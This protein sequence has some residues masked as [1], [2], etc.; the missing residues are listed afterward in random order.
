M[1]DVNTET[2]LLQRMDAHYF[3]STS[4]IEIYASGLHTK[5]LEELTNFFETHPSQS[6]KNYMAN[7]WYL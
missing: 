2:R 6:D 4:F 7:S 1:F 5:A 3:Q